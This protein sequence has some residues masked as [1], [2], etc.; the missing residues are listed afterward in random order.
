MLRF[1]VACLIISG[2]LFLTIRSVHIISADR[3]DTRKD[4]VWVAP[5]TARIPSTAEGELIRYGRSL[6]A[7]TAAY[8][9]PQ[10]KLARITNGM[11]C[12]NCHLRAGAMPW[13]NNLGA[14]SSTYPRFRERR[15]AVE[16]IC[17]RINDCLER[18]LNGQA[19]DTAG[20]EMRAMLSYMKWLG[21]DV[22]RGEKPAG[23]GIRSLKFLDRAADPA[24]GE[25]IYLKK[26]VSCHGPDGQGRKDSSGINYLYP[27]LWGSNSYNTASGLYRISRFAGYVMDNMPFG[28]SRQNP[29]LTEEEA[30]D[31]AA[32]VN[33]RPRPEKNFSGDWPD[34]ALKPVDHPFGPFADS[35]SERQ[36][37]YGPYAPIVLA[38]NRKAGH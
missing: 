9:G 33:S 24:K 36:H 26:C 12:Q 3:I 6:I 31:L 32:F 27:P 34:K 10:G 28:A 22:P 21:K 5:D 38:R 13:G 20:L 19:M 8:L 4:P 15:G 7:G 29:G 30:W 14:V 37:K 23:T 17:Q 11:N 35:F 25:S 18:S 16:T 2:V 1:L